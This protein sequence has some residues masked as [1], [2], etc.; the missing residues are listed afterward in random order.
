V[1]INHTLKETWF[2]KTAME[3]EDDTLRIQ[4]R[5]GH[6]DLPRWLAYKAG[7]EDGEASRSMDRQHTGIAG[8]V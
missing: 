8:Q 6:R 1:G 3:K 7:Q 5:R 4:R 2:T